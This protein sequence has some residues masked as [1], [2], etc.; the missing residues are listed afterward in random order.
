MKNKKIIMLVKTTPK[1]KSAKILIKMWN[2]YISKLLINIKKSDLIVYYKTK[3]DIII[4]T[5]KIKKTKII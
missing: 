4:N 2:I 5:F 3:Y 1:W